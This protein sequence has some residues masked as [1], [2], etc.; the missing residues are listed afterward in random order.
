MNSANKKKKQKMSNQVQEKSKSMGALWEKVSKS[1]N[2]FLGGFVE[3]EGV[4]HNIV[5]FKNNIR[6]KDTSPHYSILLSNPPVLQ[7][8]NPPT[9]KQTVKTS[10]KDEDDAFGF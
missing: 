2:K 3:I 9:S 6:E 5:V 10:V 8:Q 7:N 4:R 1:N